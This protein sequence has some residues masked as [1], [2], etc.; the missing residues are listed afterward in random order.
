MGLTLDV[1]GEVR[2]VTETDFKYSDQAVLASRELEPEYPSYT[3][4]NRADT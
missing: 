1:N 2:S 4:G 3:S